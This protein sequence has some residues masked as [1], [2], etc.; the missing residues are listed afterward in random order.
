MSSEHSPVSD[1]SREASEVFRVDDNT[2]D[3][4]SVSSEPDFM[5]AE[6]G[7]DR[8]SV[9]ANEV[10]SESKV[11]SM[12][13]PSVVSTRET[14]ASLIVLLIQQQDAQ[15]RREAEQRRKER[16]AKVKQLEDT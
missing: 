6:T 1:A 11:V 14:A 9:A 12:N 8:Q 3:T 4:H 10:A 15:R 16:A 5:M 13:E 2:G 7:P